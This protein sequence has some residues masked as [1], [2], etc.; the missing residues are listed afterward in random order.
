MDNQIQI[1]H[2]TIIGKM[3]LIASQVGV[4]GCCIIED[5]VTLW[6]QVGIISGLTIE[7][8]TVLMAQTG[9][10]KSLKKGV[11]FGT[12]QREYRQTLR[13]VIYLK[14]ATNKEKK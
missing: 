10:T 13:E 14:N 8:G 12:P 5:E 9:V 1:G 3:C 2:D 11:Y 6:G 7:K 4:A